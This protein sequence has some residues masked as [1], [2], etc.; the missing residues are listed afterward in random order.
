M[1]QP[2]AAAKAKTAAK[3]TA[4]ATTNVAG[5][6]TETKRRAAVASTR[7][8]MDTDSE[9]E[10]VFDSDSDAFSDEV[11]CSLVVLECV[12]VLSSCRAFE[13]RISSYY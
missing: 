9:D 12:R 10:G 8:M 13:H 1:Q 5:K 2:K 7:M 3:A 6:A 11:S 4:K